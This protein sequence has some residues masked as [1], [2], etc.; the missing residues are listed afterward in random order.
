MLPPLLAQA[1]AT[2]PADP[3][4]TVPIMVIGV[5]IVL[6][7]SWCSSRSGPAGPSAPGDAE[8]LDIWM[9]DDGRLLNHGN[10]RIEAEVQHRRGA[11]APIPALV[12]PRRWRP[13][14]LDRAM[15]QCP[16]PTSP[17]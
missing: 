9:L 6:V 13:L 4:L 16:T 2:G 3:D 8:E 11:L 12:K 15:K 1:E 7:A 17:R 5:C 10:R 14:G